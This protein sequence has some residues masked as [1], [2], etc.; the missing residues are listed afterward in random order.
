MRILK[1]KWF[2]RLA[3]KD[4]INDEML[5]NAI[6]EVEQGLDDGELG[7]ICQEAC[8]PYRQRQ[9]RRLQSNYCLSPRFSIGVFIWL[10]QERKVYL[11]PGRAG[12][13]LQIG[14]YIFSF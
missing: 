2:A 8:C 14:K 13:L 4:H 11:E 6:R 3:R 9:D 7:R 1:T 12:H 10:S 5:M